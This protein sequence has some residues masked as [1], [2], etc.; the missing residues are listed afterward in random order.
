M[1]IEY[2]KILNFG[3]L[4]MLWWI[5]LKIEIT[6]FL[7]KIKLIGTPKSFLFK[8]SLNR[9]DCCRSWYVHKKRKHKWYYIKPDGALSI[10]REKKTLVFVSWNLVYYIIS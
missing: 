8:L 2:L 10:V 4:I 7:M 5:I 1:F 3:K 9:Y 6:V